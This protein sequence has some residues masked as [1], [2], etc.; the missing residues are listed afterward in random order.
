MKFANSKRKESPVPSLAISSTVGNRKTLTSSSSSPQSQLSQAKNNDQS[1]IKHASQ[2]GNKSHLVQVK[3]SFQNDDNSENNNTNAPKSTSHN[4]SP[5]PSLNLSL[6]PQQ[7]QAVNIN[8][9]GAISSAPELNISAKRPLIP[10]LNFESIDLSDFPPHSSKVE[11]HHVLICFH[12]QKQ[13]IEK[14]KDLSKLYEKDF[15]QN[16]KVND[17]DDFL[18]IEANDNDESEKNNIPSIQTI[19]LAFQNLDHLP[20]LIKQTSNESSHLTNVIDDTLTELSQLRELK[21][22]LKIENALIKERINVGHTEM[23]RFARTAEQMKKDF[24]SF[25]SKIQGI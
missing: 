24:D 16:V 5:I 11:R 7:N 25:L 10:G 12:Y 2:T 22:K 17:I 21:E 6:A 13:E 9:Y 8:R 23:K 19:D 15:N 14:E 20:E 1:N 18:V 4:L 3:K